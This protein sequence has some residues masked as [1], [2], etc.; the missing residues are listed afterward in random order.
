[1]RSKLVSGALGLALMTT[2]AEALAQTDAT[3]PPVEVDWSA[4]LRADAQ[5]MHDA[6]LNNHPGPVNTEDPAFR[7][8]LARGLRLAL[9]R[10]E[11]AEGANAY[12]FAMRQ[13][14]ASFNDN[15][16][17][18]TL[19]NVPT[20]S[21]WPGFVVGS[22]GGAVVVRDREPDENVPPLGARLVSCDDVSAERL[23]ARLVGVFRGRW[24]SAAQRSFHTWRT[25]IDF[26]NPYV[27]RPRRCVFA[28]DGRRTTYDL[29]WRD[30]PPDYFNTRVA[31]AISFFRAPFELRQFSGGYWLSV[32]TFD[33]NPGTPS[34]EALPGLIAQLEAQREA[35]RQARIIVLDVR[36]NGGGSS[37]WSRLIANAIWGE[38]AVSQVEARLDAPTRVDWRVS[39]GNR[40]YFEQFAA[41]LRAADNGS[42]E[43]AQ[44]AEDVARGIGEAEAAGLQLWRQPEDEVAAITSDPVAPLTQSRVFV[45]ADYSCGSA[46]L[47]AM[48]LWLGLGAL[49]VGTE[50]SAD[51]NYMDVRQITLPSGHAAL[52]L[53]QKVYRGRI[54]GSNQPYTP[55][56]PFDGDIADTA[57]LEA[58]ILELA[59]RR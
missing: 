19:T 3:P 32:G 59:A 29:S 42:A 11:R 5:A 16:L 20:P 23:T 45:L 38:A 49:H 33:A 44:W 31:R 37:H 57:A 39:S 15:H 13:F 26:D 7:R 55:N 14:Q 30:T 28:A 12:V 41:S 22:N 43:L 40:A 34:A 52:V 25:F 18:L 47:D 21:R 6:I 51:S 46:C 1:M 56:A 36:G 50:T 17:D 27:R 10:A 53:P 8:V 4:A 24:N 35:V 58:F 2:C 54:R 9:A 48:D